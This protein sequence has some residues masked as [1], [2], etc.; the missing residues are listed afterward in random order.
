MLSYP[1]YNIRIDRLNNI[2]RGFTRIRYYIYLILCEKWFVDSQRQ[3]AKM[4]PT[5]GKPQ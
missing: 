2:F 1:N 3:K 5:T 4:A